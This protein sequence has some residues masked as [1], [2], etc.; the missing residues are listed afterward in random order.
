MQH[1]FAQTAIAA[2]IFAL[3]SQHASAQLE[4]VVVT[5]Q[6][7]SQSMQDVPVAVSAFGGTDIEAMGWESP[8]DVAAHDR[9]IY[10]E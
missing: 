10:A 3:S 9:N 2:A 7:R 8:A 5:A 1:K 4:E 6:K